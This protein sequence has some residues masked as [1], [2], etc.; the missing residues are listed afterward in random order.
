MKKTLRTICSLLVCLTLTSSVLVSAAPTPQISHKVYKGNTL[1]TDTSSL[2]KV[3]LG[4]TYSQIPGVFTF[5]GGPHRDGGS[6]GTISPVLKQLEK[7]WTF[8]THSSSWGGGAGWTGQ[9]AIVKWPTETKA[10]MN[11]YPGFKNDPNFVEVIYASLAGYV[12]FLDLA[13]GKPSRPS[14]KIGNPIKG[15]VSV[16]PRGYPLL[17]VGEGIPEKGSIGYNIYSLIDGTRLYHIN[18]IDPVAGR[19]WGAFDCSS[20]IDGINDTMIVGGENGLLYVVK[21]M[22][23]YN[24][25]KGTI[26]VNPTVYKLKYGISGA[27][28]KGIESSVAIHDNLVYFADNSGHITCVNL[29]TLQPLWTFNSGD[30]TDASVVLE[31]ENGTP[32]LYTGNEVDFQGT[33]G[34]CTIRKLNGLTGQE[35]WKQTFPCKSIIGSKAV[36]GGMLATPVIG[37]NNLKDLVIFSIARYNG[38]Q[39]GLMLAVNKQTGK[40]VW[41][42][43][44]THYMW[45]SPVAV[46]D[47]AGTGYL[48]QCDSAGNMFLLDGRTGKELHKINLGSNIE[49]TPAIYNNTI[50]VAPRGTKIIG[51]TIK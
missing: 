25:T 5:R 37:K 23:N 14:I 6:Y 20:L 50:V 46:Y 29:H 10:H 18:G 40:T 22:T 11:L 9:P 33:S 47:S 49:A 35:V 27:P 12:Y 51:V 30:D 24:K 19:G 48:I 21:L 4:E 2:P 32:F 15:S 44:M 17:Y 1:M 45:S 41:S 31:V 28:Q 16:D 8:S 3:K 7:K 38:M 34:T 43:Q 13:T 39:P 42:K 36:N 26:S